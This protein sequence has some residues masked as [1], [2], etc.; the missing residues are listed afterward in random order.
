MPDCLSGHRSSILRISAKFS[1]SLTGQT[2][3]FDS[4]VCRFEPYS[5]NQYAPLA[6]S[7]RAIAL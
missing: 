1:D 3:D 4:E 6:Q 5:E 7:A 2:S